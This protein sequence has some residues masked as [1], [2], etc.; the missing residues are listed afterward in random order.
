[1]AERDQLGLSALELV[2]DRRMV[3]VLTELSAG[4]IRPTQLERAL[5]QAS[6]SVLMR[7]LRHLVGNGLAGCEQEA[8]IPPR[9]GA[10]AVPRRAFYGLTDAGERLLDVAAEADRWEHACLPELNVGTLALQLSANR[11][12]RD[13]LLALADGPLAVCDVQARLP[14]LARS[15][16]W[17]R[18]RALL[19]AGLLDR[20]DVLG[21]QRY[22]LTGPARRL[23]SLA[24]VA[25]R[26]EWHWFRPDGA[27]LGSE[28]IDSLRLVAPLVC[29]SPHLSGVC[30]IR[31]TT[32]L[33]PTNNDIHLAVRTGAL[34]AL[35]RAPAA[36]PR[37]LGEATDEAWCDVL[38]GADRPF[39]ATGETSLLVA[40]VGAIRSALRR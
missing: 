33:Q 19:D 4:P 1:M 39:R 18:L 37:A 32:K 2:A 22:A 16:L 10:P 5:P 25:A 34:V 29:V 8:G 21:V 31:F 17:R 23:A 38:L 20:Q 24:M 9:P 28:V 13:I 3:R 11:R 15:T 35:R 26:W 30:Q 12:T 6:H 7:R 36:P 40:V 27:S 14:E